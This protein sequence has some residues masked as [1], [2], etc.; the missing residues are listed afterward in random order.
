MKSLIL[1]VRGNIPSLKNNKRILTNRATGKPF[2]ASSVDAKK[3]MR[4]HVLI[5]RAERN[6]QIGME[7][8]TKCA[9][10]IR[11]YD[12]SKRRYDL[13][14]RISTILDTLTQAGVIVDDDRFCVWAVSAIN[15]PTES[16]S[17]WHIRIEGET[18]VA[19]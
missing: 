5:F 3:W 11:C 10:S 18:E 7:R 13:D 1:T 16:G 14:N 17:G 15:E 4:D 9:V 19:P 8:F 2:V 12:E 6:A